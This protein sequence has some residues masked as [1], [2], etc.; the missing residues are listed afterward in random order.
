[1]HSTCHSQFPSELTVA[2]E[3]Y[4]VNQKDSMSLS[5]PDEN[6]LH[7]FFGRGVPLY[8]LT[9]ISVWIWSYNVRLFQVIIGDK[10]RVFLKKSDIVL[11]GFHSHLSFV[12]AEIMWS[13]LVQ[14][15]F[16]S[17]FIGTLC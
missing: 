6:T 17:S 14:T 15:S 7:N 4:A 13:P 10:L 12:T 1:M 9:L 3:E 16:M 5:F 2:E 11:A 8:L